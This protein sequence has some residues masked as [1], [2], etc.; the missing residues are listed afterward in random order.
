[1]A[2][3]VLG[4]VQSHTHQ[5]MPQHLPLSNRDYRLGYILGKSL[6]TDIFLMFGDDIN[7]IITNIFLNIAF[8]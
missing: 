3:G 5:K 7:R 1:M 6:P 4:D 2:E 8:I